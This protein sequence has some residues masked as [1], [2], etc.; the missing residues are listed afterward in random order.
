MVDK[1][2]KL[3]EIQNAIS[4][5]FNQNLAGGGVVLIFLILSSQ[6]RLPRIF[7]SISIEE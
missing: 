3:N 6:I 7:E 5:S 2:R 4:H 1:G